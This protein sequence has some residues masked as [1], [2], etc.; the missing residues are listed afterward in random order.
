MVATYFVVIHREVTT[1]KN[2]VGRHPL[3]LVPLVRAPNLEISGPTWTLTTR[4]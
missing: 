1:Q 4:L 2:V 3:R